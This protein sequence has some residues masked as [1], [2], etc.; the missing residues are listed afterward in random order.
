MKR[1]PR[2]PSEI[3]LAPA[4]AAA[5]RVV[6]EV[7]GKRIVVAGNGKQWTPADVTQ[8]I[9]RLPTYRALL[10]VAELSRAE[11]QSRATTGAW[12]YTRHGT[13]VSEAILA[14]AALEAVLCSNDFREEPHG[15]AM[16]V[17]EDV[18]ER[19][20]GLTDED[21]S[22]GNALGAL[23][24][25]D[26]KSFRF[27]R[28]LRAAIARLRFIFERVWPRLKK[29]VGRV[30]QPSEE[31]RLATGMSLDA[32][33]NLAA[34]CA[35]RSPGGV[36]HREDLLRWATAFVGDPEAGE[37][38]AATFYSMFSASYAELRCQANCARLHAPPRLS[39][40]TFNPLKKWP[41]V[42]PEARVG[43]GAGDLILPLPRLLVE[44]AGI[45][46]FYDIAE[47]HQTAGG[48]DFR[49]AFGQALEAYVG[50]L[51]RSTPP[52]G[53]LEH[54]VV[55]ESTN[56]EACDWLLLEADTAMA[57]EV[58]T[59]SIAL[60]Q[61]RFGD[62]ARLTA[63]LEK[64]ALR[65]A[66]SQL[67]R[68]RRSMEAEGI[69]PACLRGRAIE[70]VMVVFDAP[71]FANAIFRRELEAH[72]GVEDQPFVDAIHIMSIEAFETLLMKHAGRSL[73]EVLRAKRLHP[74]HCQLDFED[75][76]A[77][78]GTPGPGRIHPLIADLAGAGALKTSNA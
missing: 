27:D 72:V 58:K 9:R 61:R 68:L 42:R 18:L 22:A 14:E 55:F 6:A 38:L 32:T 43:C 67:L 16:R 77:L 70:L 15:K 53:D 4:R 60:E 59:S 8:A 78:D 25:H 39:R 64:S 11:W 76:L 34:S 63:A 75:W 26:E 74:D 52:R 49:N 23:V 12:S 7:F 21:L 57:F 51:L 3:R 47:R 73:F 44:R 50:D 31:Y 33:A 69:G 20:H 17:I 40:Y 56:N 46:P 2:R 48:N 10:C 24:R 36:V 28:Q 30:K 1:A 35:V 37:A 71:A 54:S 29:Q 45:G 66:T 5:P 65:T 41:L 62:M 19:I 13:P